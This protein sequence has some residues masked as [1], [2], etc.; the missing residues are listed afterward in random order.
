MVSTRGAGENIVGHEHYFCH[1]S[2]SI[3]L[4]LHTDVENST[5]SNGSLLAQ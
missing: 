1:V 4:Q 2:T 3:L 5:L